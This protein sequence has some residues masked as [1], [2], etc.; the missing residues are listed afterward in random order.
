MLRR[1]ALVRTDVSDELSASFIRVRRIGE[2]GTALAVTNNQRTLRRNETSVLTRATRRNIPEDTILYS[3]RRENLKSYRPTDS[4][5]VWLDDKLHVWRKPRLFILSGSCRLVGVNDTF[6]I[7]AGLASTVILA[8][9]SRCTHCHIILSH[10]RDSTTSG[11]EPCNYI[12]QGYSGT[13]VFPG[14]SF[15]SRGFLRPACLLWSYLNQR[16]HGLLEV[17]V[18]SHHSYFGTGP[19]PPTVLKLTINRNYARSLEVVGSKP[20][21]VLE[22]FQC[23]SWPH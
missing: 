13:V 11:S 23:T 20:D 6:T 21:E 8:S 15:P 19:L 3:H 17:R 14:T 12:P 2:L 22:F 10:S 7:A 16:K 1:V 9:E 18:V 4:L 5:Q